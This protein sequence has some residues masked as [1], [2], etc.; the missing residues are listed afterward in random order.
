MKVSIKKPDYIKGEIKISGSKNSA[1]PLLAL[2]LLTREKLTFLN[3]PMIC[4]IYNM[5]NLLRSIGVKVNVDYN[6]N[7]VTLKRKKLK[8][9]LINS[10]VAKIRASYYLYPGLINK[11][12]RSKVITPGG[13]NFTNRPIDYHL[14]I[15]RKTGVKVQTKESKIIFTKGKDN[16]ANFTFKTPSVGATINAIL[17]SVLIKGTSVIN[18]QP[19]EPEI[20]DVITCL[21]M[22]GANIKTLDNKIIINGVRKLKKVKYKVMPDRIELGSYLLLASSIPSFVRFKNINSKSIFYLTPYLDKLGINYIYN[23]EEIIVKQTNKVNGLNVTVST[24]PSFPTDLQPILCSLLTNAITSSKVVDEV[25]PSRISHIKEINKLSGD[26]SFSNNTINITP[27]KLTGSNVYAHD[28]RCGFSLI[29]CACLSDGI[30][31]I[32]NFEVIFR[33]YENII[34]KLKSLGI[35]IKEH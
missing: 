18:N 26:I 5:L 10:D 4:D 15:F 25:Y 13:C 8:R 14:D 16:P 31:T 11:H 33:G 24:Y 17:R 2:C 3:V 21:N 28:L 1:L 27:S 19:I 9:E 23:K 6:N 22:M 29:I 12:K 7:K 32:E 30:T 35:Q 20:E 34:S